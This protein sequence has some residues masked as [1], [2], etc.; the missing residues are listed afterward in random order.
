MFRAETIS[1]LDLETISQEIKNGSG[2][3][4]IASGSPRKI[5]SNGEVVMAFGSN[6]TIDGCERG[7]GRRDCFAA[8]HT[9]KC[10]RHSADAR[11]GS[12]EF[13]FADHL[14]CRSNR[15]AVFHPDRSFV[16]QRRPIGDLKIVSEWI[17][18]GESVQSALVPFTADYKDRKHEMIGAYS[19]AELRQTAKLSASS[20]CRTKARLWRRSAKCEMQTWID[21][22]SV[23]ALRSD[24]GLI[25]ARYMTSLR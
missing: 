11:R 10:R 7:G 21:Q 6:V 1:K 24:V 16:S 5:P 19:T 4:K 9:A 18:A 8:R 23:C 20:R 25:G 14:C 12:L 22:F 13:R 2:D 17:E 3:G 15:A